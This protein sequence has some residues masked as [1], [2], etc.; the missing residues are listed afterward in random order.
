MTIAGMEIRRRHGP[1]SGPFPPS[2]F[3]SGSD[4]VGRSDLLQGGQ[5]AE[6]GE[7][8]S[9]A[10]GRD[11]DIFKLHRQSAGLSPELNL[12]GVVGYPRVGH[13]P[14]LCF[15]EAD[16]C[17]AQGGSDVGAQ[18]DPSWVTPYR[19]EKALPETPPVLP[20]LKGGELGMPGSGRALR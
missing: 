11:W 13:D 7:V 17:Q 10:I 19:F 5:D 3:F 16:S 20:F 9:F 6:A 15:F 2:F 14:D 8:G 1:S 18:G 4:A 12:M